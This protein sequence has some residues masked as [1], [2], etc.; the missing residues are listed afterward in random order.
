MIASTIHIQSYLATHY[1]DVAEEII[2]KL[3]SIKCNPK[4]VRKISSLATAEEHWEYQLKTIAAVLVLCSPETI[5]TKSK[6]RNGIAV[7][8]SNV[9]GVSRQAVCHKVDRA[10]HYYLNVARVREAV[11]YIVKEVRGDE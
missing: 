3:T 2:T 8:I 11:D 4:L 5:H 10:R 9:L 6:V 7:S 1:P